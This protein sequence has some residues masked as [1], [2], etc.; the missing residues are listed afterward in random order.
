VNALR[1]HDEG[2]GE[3]LDQLR[4]AMGKR[5]TV[6]KSDKIVFDLPTTITHQFETALK[7]KIIE[8]TTA[9]WEFWFGLLESFK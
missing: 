3:E 6:G 1:S 9:S 2:L 7:T 4:Q 8:S 5:G